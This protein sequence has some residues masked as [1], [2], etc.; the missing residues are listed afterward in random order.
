MGSIL[1]DLE[2]AK[3]DPFR[4]ERDDIAD[5]L[6]EGNQTSYYKGNFNLYSSDQNGL[7]VMAI[8]RYFLSFI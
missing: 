6:E 4:T 1:D 2:F 5:G 7:K 3:V 8:L